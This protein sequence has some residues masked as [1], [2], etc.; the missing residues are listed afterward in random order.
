MFLSHP[1][2]KRRNWLFGLEFLICSI[3]NA[4][5]WHIYSIILYAGTSNLQLSQTKVHSALSWF[6]MI[7]S[8]GISSHS[9]FRHG[10]SSIT[11][12]IRSLIEKSYEIDKIR[13]GTWKRTK[14]IPLSF[15]FQLF[16]DHFLITFT[17]YWKPLLQCINIPTIRQEHHVLNARKEVIFKADHYQF[18]WINVKLLMSNWVILLIM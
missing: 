8:I 3:T 4:I 14:S 18:I 2:S 16:Q 17:N 15:N 13:S 7:H 5:M 9:T 12:D 11:F 10:K 6:F 1:I